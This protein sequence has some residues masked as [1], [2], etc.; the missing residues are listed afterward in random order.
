MFE[1]CIKKALIAQHALI[2]GDWGKENFP[3]SHAYVLEV[4]CR[5]KSLDRHNYLLDIVDLQ[6]AIDALVDRYSDKMLN[7][8]PEFKDT[9]PSLELFARVLH[10]RI[11]PDLQ[12]LG[13]SSFTIKLW[14]NESCWASYSAPE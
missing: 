12:R 8:L 14:E 7:D 5:G 6:K 13:V 2:G 4:L 3:H 1:L 11:K 9:N 10:D